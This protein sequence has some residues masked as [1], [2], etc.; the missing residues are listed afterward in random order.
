MLLLCFQ[1]HILFICRSLP[2]IWPSSSLW[3]CKNSSCFSVLCL[4]YSIR[5]HIMI[6]IYIYNLDLFVCTALP[7]DE[8]FNSSIKRQGSI[9]LWFDIVNNQ[10]APYINTKKHNT[11]YILKSLQERRNNCS[12]I[13]LN[14]HE[15]GIP[16]MMYGNY[17]FRVT[18]Q[19]SGWSQD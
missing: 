5:Y 8:R 7:W 19:L 1:V 14:P 3:G 13:L 4:L 9:I 6:D 10:L 2:E 11:T 18:S 15:K 16:L 12:L 17:Y